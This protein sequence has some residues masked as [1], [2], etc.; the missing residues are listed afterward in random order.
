MYT[1]DFI[2]ECVNMYRLGYST[3]EISRVKKI[4]LTTLNSWLKRVGV[5]LRDKKAAALLG[6]KRGRLKPPYSGPMSDQ[7]KKRIGRKLSER[8]TKVSDVE[9]KKVSEASKKSWERKSEEDRL[10]F[11]KMGSLAKQKTGKSGSKWEHYFLGELIK[12]GYACEFHKKNII[13]NEKMEIDI[14]LTGQRIAIEIDGKHHFLPIY[15]EVQL[16]KKI[17]AD[18]RKNGLLLKAGYRVLR[19]R[20]NHQTFTE[21]LASRIFDKILRLLEKDLNG[22]DLLYIR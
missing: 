5:K 3:S 10:K 8:W 4:P 21:G 14:L 6:I 11:I 7:D 1:G 18:E 22:Q 20:I 12:N 17:N 9:K 13:L 19:V 16:A 15:G 2:N